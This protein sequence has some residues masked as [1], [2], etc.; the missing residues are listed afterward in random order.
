MMFLETMRSACVTA[1]ASAIYTPP[2]PRVA[3]RLRVL[4]C[5]GVEQLARLALRLMGGDGICA[6][7]G[8]ER[9]FREALPGPLL[10]PSDNTL[11]E[12]AGREILSAGGE[13][14]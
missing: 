10:G 11:C 13:E 12:D 5:D 7:G 2:D 1:A 6:D 4:V 14:L 8:F 3:A 9:F